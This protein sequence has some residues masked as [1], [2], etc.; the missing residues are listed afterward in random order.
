MARR[1]FPNFDEGLWRRSVGNQK[2]RAEIVNDTAQRLIF[3]FSDEC[4]A[5]A[6][7]RVGH[8]TFQQDLANQ[9]SDDAFKRWLD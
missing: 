4:H 8:H 1:T 3:L 6:G 2:I 9:I 5:F 7:E